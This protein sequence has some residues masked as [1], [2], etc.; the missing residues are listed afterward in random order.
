M[1]LICF[2][3]HLTYNNL[4][5]STV[6]IDRRLGFYQ[7]KF[8]LSGNEV[9]FVATKQPRLITYNLLHIQTNSFVIKEE[10]GFEDD[11]IKQ[12]ILNK[13]RLLMMSKLFTYVLKTNATPDFVIHILYYKILK[14]CSVI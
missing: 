3:M 13:P 11:E 6:R 10:M 9:R 1:F 7:E 5:F 12:L 2:T 8:E 4:S 14:L